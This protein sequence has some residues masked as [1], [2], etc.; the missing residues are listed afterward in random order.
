MATLRTVEKS[1]ELSLMLFGK[2]AWELD[3]LEGNDVSF[4]RLKE[5]DALGKELQER[6]HWTSKLG[7]E[8]LDHG[9]D[10]YACLYDIHF[11]KPVP[12]EQAKKELRELGLNPDE[13]DLE[14]EEIEDSEGE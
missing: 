1:T 9:W 2:P 3:G 14:E 6:L 8:L 7:R 13:M 10:A 4:E 5:I 12:L 11:V